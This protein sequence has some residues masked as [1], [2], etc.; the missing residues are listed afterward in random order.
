MADMQEVKDYLMRVRNIDQDIDAKQKAANMSQS[1]VMNVQAA[2]M[3]DINVQESSRTTAE[4]RIVKYLEME[5]E[6]NAMIDNM[7]DLKSKIFK[8]INLMS[9]NTLKA[10]LIRRYIANESWDTI[11]KELS[12]TKQHITKKHGEALQEFYSYNAKEV[13]K[14]LKKASQCV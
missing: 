11:A 8:E 4:D 7:I 2:A 13:D 9:D 6:I 1:R 3:K 12:Y 14:Y 10:V 5:E